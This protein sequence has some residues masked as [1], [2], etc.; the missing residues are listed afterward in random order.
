MEERGKIVATIVTFWRAAG[1]WE[2]SVKRMARNR[3]FMGDLGGM[4]RGKK[5]TL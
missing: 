4:E 2:S 5:R 3:G 1:L